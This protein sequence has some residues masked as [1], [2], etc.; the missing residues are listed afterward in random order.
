LNLLSEKDLTDCNPSAWRKRTYTLHLIVSPFLERYN[1]IAG[2]YRL[3]FLSKVIQNPLARRS[4]GKDWDLE[5]RAHRGVLWY[6]LTQNVERLTVKR[7][8]TKAVSKKNSMFGTRQPWS[9]A[10][11]KT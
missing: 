9:T 3:A 10:L 2:K 6:R 1:A 5:Y 11:Y 8:F 7:G 4:L